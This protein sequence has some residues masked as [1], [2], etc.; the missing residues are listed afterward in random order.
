MVLSYIESLI[1]AF[2]SS[3]IEYYVV[4]MG[5]NTWRKKDG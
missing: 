5:K 4:E 1:A 2:D 3:G